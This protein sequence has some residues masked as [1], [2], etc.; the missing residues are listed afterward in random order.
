MNA[1]KTLWISTYLSTAFYLF[2]GIMRKFRLFNLKA[3]FSFP[4]PA[5]SNVIQ[6]IATAPNLPQSS[7]TWNTVLNVLFSFLVY[8]TSIPVAMI[9]V[10]LN[11]VS[12]RLCS[13]RNL[14]YCLYLAIASFFGVT[15]PFIICIPMLT[16]TWNE[17]FRN[18]SY[19]METE[20]WTSIFFQGPCNFIFPFLIYLFLSKRNLVMQQSVLDEVILEIELII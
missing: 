5:G 17:N 14:F 19:L 20:T 10:Q 16:G 9:I 4:V 7:L 2:V 8:L 1:Q 6:A 18:F 3:G 13:K 15:V 11:L 12:S